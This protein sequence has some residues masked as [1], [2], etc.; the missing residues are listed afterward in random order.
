MKEDIMRHGGTWGEAWIR[1]GVSR[2]LGW[3]GIGDERPQV[4]GTP[5][6]NQSGLAA[7]STAERKGKMRGDRGL[8]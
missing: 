7:Q 8:K 6:R 1:K 5:M 3:A 4:C 2:Y